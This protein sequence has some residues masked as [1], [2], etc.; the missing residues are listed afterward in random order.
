MAKIRLTLLMDSPLPS[1]GNFQPLEDFRKP[2]GSPEN[3]KQYKNRAILLV[4][5]RVKITHSGY[6]TFGKHHWIVTSL[7]SDISGPD[8][9]V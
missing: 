4:S 1:N 9:E 7:Q 2:N 8:P 6:K 5:R 3:C